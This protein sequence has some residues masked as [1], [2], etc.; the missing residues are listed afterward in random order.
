MRKLTIRQLGTCFAGLL[1]SAAVASASVVVYQFPL[2]GL[3][4]VPPVVTPGLGFAE[5]TLDT[6]TNLLTWD[7]S[8]QDMLGTLTMAHFHG[9]AAIGENNSVLV[10]MFPT[11]GSNFGTIVG[12]TTVTDT[13]RDHILAG[14]TYI[15]LH[16]SV[17][18]GGELRGQVI[19]EPGTYALLAG[20]LAM[21]GALYWRRRRRAA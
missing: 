14:M 7:V 18:G 9:P 1:A 19:P 2:S 10:N 12:S 8:Y 15:N 11:T 21:G 17:H 6:N 13:V 20:I 16:S 3:E 4:E 5:V